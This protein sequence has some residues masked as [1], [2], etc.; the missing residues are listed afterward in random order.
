MFNLNLPDG[1]FNIKRID[2]KPFIWDR[3][4][5]KYVALTPEEWVRQHFVNYLIVD[6]QYPEALMANEVQISLNRQ[7]KRCDSVVYK[8]DLSSLVIIE[9][10][11]PDIK[12]DQYVFDQIVRYNI[13]LRVK[14][15]I[16][17]NGIQHYCCIVDYENQTYRFLTDIPV[18]KELD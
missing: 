14:Y 15:L 7:K 17:S 4:R 2:Q 1:D 5:K 13:V 12:I 16:V 10:K 9:Y 18:Y 8:K 6:K 3:L 11:A